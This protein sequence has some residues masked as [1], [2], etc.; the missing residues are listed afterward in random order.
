MLQAAADM[1]TMCP[2][3][4]LRDDD[5]RPGAKLGRAEGAGETSSEAFQFEPGVFSTFTGSMR[6]ICCPSGMG[7]PVIASA[8]ARSSAD[9]VGGEAGDQLYFQIATVAHQPA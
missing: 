6:I 3:W 2:Q 8:F 9:R 1:K 7:D 5:R 4:F